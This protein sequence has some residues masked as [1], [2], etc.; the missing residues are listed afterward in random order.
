M[1]KNINRLIFFNVGVSS[2][3]LDPIIIVFFLMRGLSFS[4]LM[5]LT[6][7]AYIT[8]FSTEIMS[9][10][11]ADK[12][13]D[14]R[15]IMLG[16]TFNIISVLFFIF[17]VDYIFY[18]LGSIF[19]G[20]SAS[21]ISG[22][23]ESFAFRLLN[24]ESIDFGGYI[25]RIK[26]YS[27]YFMAIVSVFGAY[28]FKFNSNLP[29]FL[30]LILYVAILVNVIR[31]NENHLT[32]TLPPNQ[33]SREKIKLTS[34]LMNILKRERRFIFVVFISVTVAIFTF[35]GKS[36]TQPILNQNS[37][38][39]MYFGII[40]FLLNIIAGYGSK[41]Y[42]DM[43][44]KVRN[45]FIELIYLAILLTFL[46]LVF[47]RGYFV[48]IPLILLNLFRG[49]VGPYISQELNRTV[50]SEYR[51]TFLSINNFFVNLSVAI[52][53]AISGF[54]V[55]KLGISGFLVLISFVIFGVTLVAISSKVR[56]SFSYQDKL[57]E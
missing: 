19:S 37:V 40:Y 32:K 36:L 55:D 23:D 21:M 57:V 54:L 26:S 29:L 35:I 51:T 15:I 4:E 49:I 28:A 6:S 56:L 3:F 16:V 38:D 10:F 22:A 5:A 7:I 14:K 12:Y 18:V 25:S 13:G 31:I 42:G 48:F 9:G 43:R 33:S 34:S 20:L 11:L 24:E 2:S 53:S 41:L 44:V 47:L 39:I 50:N 8:V 30:N 27:F 45:Y 52:S 1:K 17:A 46:L